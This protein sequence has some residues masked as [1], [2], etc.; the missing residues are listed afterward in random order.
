MACADSDFCHGFQVS[1]VAVDWM[2]GHELLQASQQV[3]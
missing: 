3:H 2:L 1:T